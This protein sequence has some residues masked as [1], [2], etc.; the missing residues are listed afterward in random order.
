MN[1]NQNNVSVEEKI[2]VAAEEIFII[3]GFKG[4]RMQEIANK[5]GVNKAMLHYYFRSKKKLFEAVFKRVLPGVFD[6]ILRV[7]NEEIPL[8]KKIEKFV[9]A[10]IDKMKKRT[11]KFP[12]FLLVS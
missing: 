12:F 2:L 6:P 10:Y 5:A 1:Q 8:F 4:C 9:N 3:E 11:C 7:I